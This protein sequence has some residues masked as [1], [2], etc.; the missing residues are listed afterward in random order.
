MIGGSGY[1]CGAACAGLPRQP[2]ALQISP[3]LREAI[4]RATT[5]TPAGRTLTVAEDRRRR[6]RCAAALR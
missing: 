3:L 4:D 6:R 2:G 5:W 1:V